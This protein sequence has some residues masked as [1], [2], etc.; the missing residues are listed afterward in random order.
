[1]EDKKEV[2]SFADAIAHARKAFGCEGGGEPVKGQWCGLCREICEADGSNTCMRDSVY[3]FLDEI[4]KW[5]NE[6]IKQ[7]EEAESDRLLK[8]YNVANESNAVNWRDC[9]SVI[10][11]ITREVI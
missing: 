6:E 9:M 1:M 8:I 3:P 11:E 7:R 5:H 4:E 10:Q 2:K